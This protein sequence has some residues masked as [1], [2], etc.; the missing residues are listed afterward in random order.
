[1][2]PRLFAEW[3]QIDEHLRR[4]ISAR[5]RQFPVAPV[6]IRQLIQRRLWD[7]RLSHEHS[8]ELACGP[9]TRHTCNGC[10]TP[11]L[12]HETMTVRIAVEDWREMRFHQ[13]CFEI[14]DEERLKAPHAKPVTPSHSSSRDRSPY[15]DAGGWQN[16]KLEM[17]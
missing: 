17:R 15:V 4:A 11:I 2:D 16:G 6:L 1:M 5:E 14:W 9:G 8:V 12:P 7:G 13:G 3:A 10:G